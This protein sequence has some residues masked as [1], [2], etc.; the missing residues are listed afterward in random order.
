[1]PEPRHP[2]TSF[3]V[4]H[5]CGHYELYPYLV[6][7]EEEV[8]LATPE[9]VL[10]AREQALIWKEAHPCPTCYYHDAAR[11]TLRRLTDLGVPQ[12]ACRASPT[13]PRNCAG[14]RTSSRRTAQPPAESQMTFLVASGRQV[15]V[16]VVL[17]GV[18]AEIPG[19]H[20]AERLAVSVARIRDEHRVHV[21]IGRPDERRAGIADGGVPGFDDHRAVG[22]VVQ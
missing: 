18:L 4:K 16:A 1:M 22:F 14:G 6:A 19:R 8:R 7:P 15:S 2:A 20:D 10:A 3:R 5:S 11:A 13:R 17:L 12:S 9:K 21:R